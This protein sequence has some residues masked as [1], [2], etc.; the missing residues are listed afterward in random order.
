MSRWL[1]RDD[2]PRGDEYDA[3]WRALEA[4]GQSIHGEADFICR[5]EPSSVLDAGCGTGRV[6]I[7]L[8]RR[9]IDVVGVDLDP[10]M[11]DSARAKAPQIEWV[12]HD[13][14]SVDVGRT[15]DVVAMPGNVMIFV[16]PGSEA[17]VV[18]NMARHLAPGGRL[19]SGFQLDHAYGLDDYERD[20]EAA[21]LEAVALY[22][23]WNGDEFDRDDPGDYA[24]LVHRRDL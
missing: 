20:A 8:A 21:G 15:F 18:A 4:A 10:N 23:T 11:L 24:V 19:I 5:F 13:L 16:Q 9:G 17:A 22:S 14:V 2:V 3:R 6:A 12:E 7:E 1:E